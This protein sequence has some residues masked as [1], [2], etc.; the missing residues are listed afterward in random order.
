MDLIQDL[1]QLQIDLFL[2]F[3]CGVDR[4]IEAID[5]LGAGLQRSRL[6]LVITLSP[7]SKTQIFKLLFGLT[8]FSPTVECSLATN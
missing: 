5:K 7:S 2:Q 4:R 8:L 6:T 1:C 3:Y